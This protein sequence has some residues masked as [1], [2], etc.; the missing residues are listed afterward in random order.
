MA[1]LALKLFG[2]YHLFLDGM[3]IDAQETDK[4]RALLAYLVTECNR[5][6][7]REKLIGLFWPEQD[8]EHARGSLSQALYHLR[9]TL[10]DRPLTG[11]L[12]ASV[13]EQAREPFLLVSPQ[14]IQFNPRS[15]FETDVS[16]FTSLVAACKLHAHPAYKICEDCLQRYLEAARLYGGDILDG[17]YL[18]QSLVFEEWATVLREQLRLE[19]MK[20]LDCLV[21]AFERQGDLD[22]ALAYARRMVQLDELGEAANGHVMRLLALLGRRGEALAHYAS[23][24]QALA[25]QMGAEPGMEINLLYQRLRSEAAGLDLGNLP[26]SL[27]PFIGRKPELDKLWAL[28]RDP[29]CRLICVLGPGGSGKTRLALEA[30]Q[31]HRY[32]FTNGVCFVSLSAL[33]P[34]SSLLASIADGLSFT[35]REYGDQKKQL[36][37]YL[38]NKKVLLVL[39]SFETVV[40]SAGLVAELLSA[41]PG[42]KALVTSRVRLNL[43]GERVF[44][45]EGMRV[46]PP[47]TNGQLWDY[48]S[49]ELFL[50]AAQRVKPGYEPGDLEGVARICRLVEGMPLGLLLASTW[51]SDYS[52]HEIAEQISRSLDFLSVEWADLPE[53]QRSLR[54]TFEYSWNLLSTYE[55][56]ILMYLS[57]FRNSFTTQA[58]YQVAGASPQV[59]HSLVSK[60]LLGSTAE[61]RYQMHDLVR[62]YSLEKLAEAPDEKKDQVHHRHG[63]YFLEKAE[64]WEKLIKGPQQSV[65]LAQVDKEIDDVQVAWEWAA[66]RADLG[67]LSQA[68][69]GL[70]LYYFLRYRFPEGKHACQVAIE[71]VQS[72]PVSG[73]GLN[74]EGWLLA[75]MVHFNR[76]LGKV[77][78]ARQLANKCLE[79][80]GEAEAVEQDTRYAQALLWRE[81]GY[82]VGSLPDQI[83]CFQH[84]AEL[85]ETLG[86]AWWQSVVLSWAGE[87]MNRMGNRILALELHQEAMAL[88]RSA[89][90]PRVQARS[91]MNLAYDHLIHWEWETGARLM[92]EAAGWFRSVGDLGSLATAELHLGVSL[93]WAGRLPEA[94]DM[95]EM[96]VVKMH[97]L[98]D[99]FYIT[100]GTLALGIIQMYSGMYEQAA[101]TLEQAWQAARLDGFRREEVH[102]LEQM[103]CLALVQ[104]ENV[105]AM[106]YLQQSVAGFRQMGFAGELGIALGGLA[107]AQHLLGQEQQAWASLQE[108]LHIATETHSR[109]TLFTLPTGLVVLLVDAGRWEQAVEAYLALMKDPI[110]SNSRWTADMIGDRMELARENLS[111]EAYLAAEARGREGDIFDVLGRLLK[112]IESWDMVHD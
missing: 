83:D 101:Q 73:E 16:G 31:R 51:V 92:Q 48:S 102:S 15:D 43:S 28:L 79:R 76:L 109:F 112:E 108:M 25:V 75:W 66:Q 29:N 45:L 74:Q 77:D 95:L 80:L 58:A 44:S 34:G 39:D 68:S 65:L 99:R 18:P 100:Y 89:G 60:C 81:R 50:E 11:E 42:S 64:R 2:T 67:M 20:V 78:L 13:R 8:E 5:P 38:R 26:A 98:G 1:S 21:T 97:Q 56:Q 30:A 46:P 88:S 22:Q 3:Y 49:V 72:A 63:V 93:G 41:S 55:Q 35:F 12:P 104:G 61:G 53:R 36:L 23:F 69:E 24:H 19:M 9:G 57:V 90:E 40:E 47:D 96:A 6:H 105:Q 70:F 85:F 32:F 54:A 33:G 87:L 94:R 37:D 103:G 17:F 4:A 106:A 27:T 82:L 84:S 14:E 59:L 10:G 62:Q 110:V 52:A 111:K 107:L 7:S 86:D 71:S 91:L